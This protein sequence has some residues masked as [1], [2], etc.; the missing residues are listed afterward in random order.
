MATMPQTVIRPVAERAGPKPKPP[1]APTANVPKGTRFQVA[2]F[3]GQAKAA[4][5]QLRDALILLAERHER[6]YDIAAGATTLAGWTRTHLEW[7]D[8]FGE[9]YGVIP[10]ESAEQ[11]RAALLGGTRAGIF[12]ILEDLCDVA[13]LA[14]RVEMTWTVLYQGSRELPDKGLPELSSRSRDHARRQIAWIRT[15]IDHIAPDALAIPLDIGG[16]AA[17]SVPKHLSSIASIPDSLW[18][19]IVAAGLIALMGVIGLIVGRPWNGPSIGPTILLVTLSP[20]HPTARAWNVLAGHLGGLAAGI[21]A[22]TLLGA[23]N[24]PSV[25]ETGELTAVR[26]AAAVL[27]IGLTVAAGMLLRASHPPAAATTLLVALGAIRTPPQVLA[28]ICAVILVAILG[29]LIRHVRLERTAPAER[30]APAASVVRS[31]LRGA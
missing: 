5:E 11:L 22:V 3:L 9:A 17:I 1:A 25:L 16:Q 29:E 14:E 2:I 26:V 20:A 31:R 7:L 28:T 4:E 13:V 10:S 21:A 30:R 24:A 8:P 23:Q 6:D 27:A 18:G 15:Q 19:P 12:G